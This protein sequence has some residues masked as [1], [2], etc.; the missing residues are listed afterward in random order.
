MPLWLPVASIVLGVLLALFGPRLARS[1]LVKV[2]W[3]WWP[4]RPLSRIGQWLF[5]FHSETS[6]VILV[7]V[8]LSQLAPAPFSQTLLIACSLC[9]ALHMVVGIFVTT[10]LLLFGVATVRPE[11]VPPR[12]PP[13]PHIM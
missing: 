12:R 13:S 2:R 4:P 6:A 8:G 1:S 10:P 11:E 7:T 3:L 9:F 5:T